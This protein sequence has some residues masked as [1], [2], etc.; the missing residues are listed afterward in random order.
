LDSLTI[1]NG[2][3]GQRQPSSSTDIFRYGWIHLQP[4]IVKEDSV[5][6]QSGIDLFRYGWIHLPTAIVKEGRFSRQ[7]S[8][9]IGIH[10]PTAAIVKEDSVSRHL[11]QIYADMVEFTYMLQ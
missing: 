4:A 7:S 8:I 5:S 3:E 6:H 2:K 1:C 11:V 9:D 10:L